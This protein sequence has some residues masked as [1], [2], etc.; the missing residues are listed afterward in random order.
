MSYSL[1]GIRAVDNELMTL[2][3][4]FGWAA[5]R[6]HWQTDDCARGRVSGE[7]GD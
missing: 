6:V 3:R 7:S 4:A 1:N 5:R 2:Q